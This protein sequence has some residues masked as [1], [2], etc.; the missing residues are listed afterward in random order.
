M[1]TACL[2]ALLVVLAATAANAIMSPSEH[3]NKCCFC[4]PVIERGTNKTKIG[5]LRAKEAYAHVVVNRGTCPPHFTD[6]K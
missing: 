3:E 4:T 5:E 2:L 6:Y 1:K